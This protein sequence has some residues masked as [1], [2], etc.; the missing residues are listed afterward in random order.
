[1][2]GL[3]TYRSLLWLLFAVH[4]ALGSALGLTVDEAHYLLYALHPALSYFDHPP[5][6]GW[7]QWPLVAWDAPIAVLRL[8]PGLLWLATVA[9]VYHLTHRLQAAAGQE[10]TVPVAHAGLWAV[11]ALALAPLLHLL[12]I[13]LLPDSLLMLWMVLLM[14]QTLT[15]MDAKAAQQPLPWVLLGVLLGLAGLSKYTA[16]LPAAAVA[17]CL[18]AAHGW[19]LLGHVWLWVA[20]ALALAMVLP[21]LVWNAQNDWV[22][23]AYQTQHGKGGAWQG[24]HLVQFLLLQLVAYGV[25]LGWG[26][27]G[28]WATRGRVRWLGLF[29]AIPFAVHALLA[30]GGTSLPHWTAPAWVALAPFAGMALAHHVRQKMGRL[31]IGALVLLQALACMVLFGLM[32]SGGRP[33]LGGGAAEVAEQ[34]NPFA[35]LHGWDHAGQR[36]LVLAHSQQLPAVAVQNW[37][38]ASRLGWYAKPLPVHVLEDRFDQFD[39]WAGDLPQG[40]NALLVDWSYMAYALPLA[41][42]G[43]SQCQWL[44]TLPVQRWGAPLGYFRFYACYGWVGAPQPTL[45]Q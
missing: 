34:P 36:A 33:W 21:V 43:F 17:V 8:L 41:P 3:F 7:L 23:F 42:H 4:F 26:V 44:E 25:L 13:G 20:S 14:G 40:G 1:M 35:D 18:L 16:I 39:I 31:C 11:L 10:A 22:S 27:V 29:F 45:L 32:L 12:G 37:T 30:G 2:P 19:R 38:L 28:W 6:V 9:G 24:V 5:L 15:L